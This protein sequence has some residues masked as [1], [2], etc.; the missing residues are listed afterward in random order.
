MS[1]HARDLMVDVLPAK[2]TRA[3]RGLQMCSDNTRIEEEDEGCS[4]NTRPPKKRTATAQTELDLAVLRH[5]LREALS[6]PVAGRP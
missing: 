3:L 4:D 5:E 2:Q 6:Q 1:F